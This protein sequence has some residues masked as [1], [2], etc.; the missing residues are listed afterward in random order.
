MDSSS[1]IWSLHVS[2]KSCTYTFLPF[3]LLCVT[4]SM[5]RFKWNAIQGSGFHRLRWS[6]KSVLHFHVVYSSHPRFVKVF[7]QYYCLTSHPCIVCRFPWKLSG[8]LIPR[9][10]DEAHCTFFVTSIC[11]TSCW[12][13][14]DTKNYYSFNAIC[15]CSRLYQPYSLFL[16][17]TPCFHHDCLYSQYLFCQ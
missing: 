1:W 17:V 13:C 14:F 9:Q 12:I 7:T 2:P 3:H 4:C 8:P 16:K 6:Q 11:W 5:Q 15:I 10:N